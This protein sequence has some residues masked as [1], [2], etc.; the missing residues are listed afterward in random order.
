MP[1]NPSIRKQLSGSAKRKLKQINDEKVNKLRGSMDQFIKKKTNLISETVNSS[2][3]DLAYTNTMTIVSSEYS[4]ATNIT[5]IYNSGLNDLEN[6]NINIILKKTLDSVDL[7]VTD[8]A[9][10]SVDTG[11]CIQLYPSDRCHFDENINCN[12]KRFVI[13]NGPCR[14]DIDFPYKIYEDGKSFRFSTFFY[15][16]KL[17]SGINVP[18]FWLCYSVGWNVAYCETCWLFANRQYAYYQD[19]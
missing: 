15:T 2:S 18:Q 11:T 3:S 17:K 8:I 1:T 12:T 10:N 19:S 7:D 4:D 16:M 13:C 5:E 6:G 14:P 9:E